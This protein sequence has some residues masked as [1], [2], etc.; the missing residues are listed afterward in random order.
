MK[1]RP[2]DERF[3]AARG[4]VYSL[5]A[6]C[7]LTVPTTAV[8]GGTSEPP[9]AVLII[10]ESDPGSGAP[11]VFSTTLRTT[12]NQARPR[13]GVYG[14]TL[15][16]RRFAEPKQKE[17]LRR[18]LQAKYQ[19]ISF[20]AI[21]AVGLSA[22]KV[23]KSWRQ[24]LWPNV[25]VVFAAID[26]LSASRLTLDPGMTGLVM[27]RTI[28]SMVAAARMLVPNLQ[29]LAVLGGTLERD[30]YRRQYIDEMPRL[31][32]ELQVSNLTGLPLAE[33]VHRAAA[34]PPKTAILYLSLFVDDAG[35]TYSA[36][37]SLAAIAKV[38]NR[39]IVVDVDSLIGAGATG[40]YVLNNVSYGRQTARLVLQILDDANVASSPVAIAE[41]TMPVFDWR[42]LRRWNI[43]EA[44]LPE[45]SEIRFRELAGWQQYWKQILVALIVVLIQSAIISALQF[46]RH[47]RQV[48][49]QLARNRRAEVMRLNQVASV[50]AMS[51]SI[52]HEL[53][54]PLGVILAN[55]E[56]AQLLLSADSPDISQALEA[57]TDIVVAD[58]RADEIITH[59]RQ[60]MKK[61]SEIEYKVFDVNDVVESAC[62]ILSFD[63]N[64]KSILVERSSVPRPLNIRADPI[65]IR[66]VLLNLGAN[67][68]DAMT[69]CPRDKRRLVIR[70]APVGQSEVMVSVLDTGTGLAEKCI[71][72]L[73][74]PFVT[75]KDQGTGLGL[76]ISRTIIETYGGR[77]WAE[78]RPQGGAAFRFTLDLARPT[79]SSPFPYTNRSINGRYWLFAVAG[80]CGTS[81]PH[82]EFISYRSSA[83][84]GQRHRS[85]PLCPPASRN[86]WLSPA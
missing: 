33:Q 62:R 81:R 84:R 17:L 26:E 28:D 58:Q 79:C 19:D 30:S 69:S 15:D 12:L 4:A 78:N 25:P 52:A 6:V 14:E 7:L 42:Q 86:Q 54:Q 60:L 82:R 85:I 47:R 39:P 56:A 44:A 74:E 27:H 72:S 2:P 10:D 5:I 9:R 36:W 50:A 73:F 21:A 63:A 53:K 35:T 3:Q 66:Q 71:G 51:S 38:A 34:F 57:I 32:N 80:S 22:L 70:T 43:S 37:D 65:H 45:G 40:G 23:V 59:L 67:A 20:G 8:A 31:T 16:L 41:F 18:Y 24:E 83:I 49:E 68:I 1:R 77:I 29:G 75:T 13:V 61:K 76:A 46:E 64:K 11:T 55:A 48:A